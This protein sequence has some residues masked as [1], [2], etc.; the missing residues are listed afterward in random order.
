MILQIIIFDPLILILTKN[1]FT[2]LFSILSFTNLNG[3]QF[4]GN[5]ND[6]GISFVEYNNHFFLVGTTRSFGK[7]S[8][9]ICL[10]K[11]DQDTNI[12]IQKTWGSIHQDHV[13]QIIKTSDQKLLIAGQSWDAPGGRTDIILIKMDSAYNE[14]WSSHISGAQDDHLSNIIELHDK[15]FMFTGMQRDKGR[16]GAISLIK[17][18][19]SGKTQWKRFF[20]TRNRSFGTDLIQSH[21]SSIYIIANTNSFLGKVANST[22]YL[23][24]LSSAGLLIKTDRNGNEIWRRNYQ[25][26]KHSFFTKI[27]YDGK[28]Y[29]YIIG[30]TLNNTNGSF[31]LFVR[32]IDSSGNTVWNKTYGGKGYEYGKHVTFDQDQNL[33]IV[34]NSSSTT[35]SPNIYI[36]KI[37]IYGN[38]IWER[39]YNHQHTTYGSHILALNNNNIAILG[40]FKKQEKGSLDFLFLKLNSHGKIISSEH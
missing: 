19:D 33:L 21:D 24:N 38:K 29:F 39:H 36:L 20:D 37:D 3:Q 18:N 26:E 16:L 15:G 8:E 30:S 28:K 6:K 22:E 23:S 31:D 13:S 25:Q 1:F 5:Q 40:S 10:L 4:G 34:S 12:L 11:Y 7:G 17:T 2:V 35:E 14:V 27:I 32:K 9:D